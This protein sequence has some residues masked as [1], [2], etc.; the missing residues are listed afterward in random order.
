MRV[1]ISLNRNSKTFL[2]V[3]RELTNIVLGVMLPTVKK[4]RSIALKNK[5][6]SKGIPMIA[7]EKILSI[8][9]LNIAL[10]ICVPSRRGRRK[11]EAR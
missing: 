3:E 7:Y 2:L 1:P 6:I 11:W 10:V 5:P 8:I 4:K 9:S